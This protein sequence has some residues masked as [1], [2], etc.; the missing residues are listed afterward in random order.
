MGTKGDHTALGTLSRPFPNQPP[1]IKASC[2]IDRFHQRK[3]SKREAC[4]ILRADC[5]CKTAALSPN[6]EI[7]GF[8]P[9]R[10]FSGSLQIGSIRHVL[11]DEQKLAENLCSSHS[12]KDKGIL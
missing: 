5:F 10:L 6:A 12:A 3:P 4:E 1:G 7:P 8:Y 9:A 11:R 2:T